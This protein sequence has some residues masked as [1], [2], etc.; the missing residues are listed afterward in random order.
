MATL[1]DARERLRLLLERFLLAAGK[2][3][4]VCPQ[5]KRLHCTSTPCL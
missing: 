3:E 4:Q 2:L 1:E 5:H